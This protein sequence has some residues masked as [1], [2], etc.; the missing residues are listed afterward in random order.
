MGMASTRIFFFLFIVSGLSLLAGCGAVFVN[1]GSRNASVAEGVANPNL[2][3]KTTVPAEARMISDFEDGTKN[4]NPKLYGSGL[5][6]WRTVS[7][8]GNM[9]NYDFVVSGG[10]SGSKSARVFGMLIDHGNARYPAFALEG[11]FKRTGYYDAGAFKGIRFYYRCPAADKAAKRRFGIG[12]ASTVPV[13]EGGVCQ[14]QCGNHFGANL[15]NS[16][17]WTQKSFLFSELKREEGWGA[18]LG[19]PEFT[20]HLREIIYI[21]WENSANNTVGAYAIDY[22]VDDVEF[23]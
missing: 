13:A 23:F 14:E 6:F 8:D 22:G 20:D 1:E 2:P 9:P 21:K 12:I 17:E 10:A 19:S 18:S 11:K 4:M 16:E 15:T 3:L 5:G 7:S